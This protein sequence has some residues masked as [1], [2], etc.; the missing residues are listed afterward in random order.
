MILLRGNPDGLYLPLF[1]TDDDDGIV[2]AIIA[3][4]G[5]A[6]NVS[7]RTRLTAVTT[8]ATMDRWTLR[9]SRKNGRVGPKKILF[10]GVDRKIM[11]GMV[12]MALIKMRTYPGPRT[13]TT[14]TRRVS[15][16]PI[17]NKNGGVY[18]RNVNDILV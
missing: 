15:E 18:K 14:M 2:A 5:V 1:V 13:R 6:F 4:A 8:C 17:P 16:T 11:V 3:V 9:K 7:I 10:G 12:R